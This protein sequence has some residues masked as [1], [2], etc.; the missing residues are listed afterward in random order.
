MSSSKQTQKQMPTT[1]REF[2]HC[3]EMRD[4]SAEVSLDRV[5]AYGFKHRKLDPNWGA[6]SPEKE[7]W[8]WKL[9]PCQ[10]YIL[11]RVVYDLLMD[12]QDGDE[13]SWLPTSN[14]RYGGREL[15]EEAAIQHWFRLEVGGHDVWRKRMSRIMCV[16]SARGFMDIYYRCLGTGPVVSSTRLSLIEEAEIFS[17]AATHMG[18][19]WGSLAGDKVEVKRE[20]IY[21]IYL[22]HIKG[23]MIKRWQNLVGGFVDYSWKKK[24]KIEEQFEVRRKLAQKSV[25]IDVTKTA[26]IDERARLEEMVLELSRWEKEIKDREVRVVQLESES[27]ELVDKRSAYLLSATTKQLRDCIIG[28]EYGVDILRDVKETTIPV[29]EILQMVSGTK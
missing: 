11:P 14:Y 28:G 9:T 19:C 29:V 17:T 1:Y 26:I 16:V 18:G 25:D 4:I 22:K 3:T 21:N 10:E 7:F 12:V 8:N 5:V 13:I 23:W 15:S 6:L 20:Y 27:E 2:I 24:Y